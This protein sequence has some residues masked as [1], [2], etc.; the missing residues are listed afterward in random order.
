MR[1]EGSAV[2]FWRGGVRKKK[3]SEMIDS[4][5]GDSAVLT[6]ALSWQSRFPGAGKGPIVGAGMLGGRSSERA[7]INLVT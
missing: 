5:P 2:R 3:R 4:F 1:A 6:I 7:G